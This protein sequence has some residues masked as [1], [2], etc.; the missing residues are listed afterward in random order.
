MNTQKIINN[1]Q[2]TRNYEELKKKIATHLY[3]VNLISYILII[4]RIKRTEQFRTRLFA[5]FAYNLN[6]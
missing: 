5:E 1:F 4:R 6:A 2:F 3:Q